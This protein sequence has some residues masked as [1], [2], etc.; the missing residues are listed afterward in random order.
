M[1]GLLHMARSGGC[2]APV[3]NFSLSQVATDHEGQGFLAF[4][5]W[6]AGDHREANARRPRS[7]RANELVMADDDEMCLVMTD[8]PHL[9]EIS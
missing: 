1:K 5:R 3:Q 9:P 7:T 4:L 8:R 6:L 2:V